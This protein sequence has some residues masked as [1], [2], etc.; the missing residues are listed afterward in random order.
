MLRHRIWERMPQLS[1]WGGGYPQ[2]GRVRRELAG[3]KP[4]SYDISN[5]QPPTSNLLASRLRDP[6]LPQDARVLRVVAQLQ[7]RVVS[8]LTESRRGP[9]PQRR[10]RHLEGRSG[11]PYRAQGRLLHLLE[12]PALLKV[13]VLLQ[14][15]RAHH[16]RERHTQLLGPRQQVPPVVF[17]EIRPERLL[18]LLPPDVAHPEIDEQLVGLQLRLLQ[19]DRHAQRKSAGAAHDNDVAVPARIDL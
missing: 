1:S 13:L 4:C 11:H 10:L 8:V 16:R 7:E 3:L 17:Q 2:A 19:Q 18:E 14:Q 12:E 6:P 9:L 15:P 5:L